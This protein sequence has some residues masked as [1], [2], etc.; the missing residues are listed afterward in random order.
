MSRYPSADSRRVFRA[1][2]V[3]L[4]GVMTATAGCVVSAD[5]ESTETM[6]ADT[7]TQE[8]SP[9]GTA[10]EEEGD[11]DR[12][13]KAGSPTG[14]ANRIA[15]E[16]RADGWIG[17]SPVEI[18]NL[19]NPTHPMEAGQTYEIVW[20]NVDGEEHEL[21]IE[22]GDGSELHASDST[23]SQ[24]ELVRLTVDASTEMDRYYCEY[25]PDTMHGQVEVSG[26]S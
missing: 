26:G 11:S 10:T 7:T 4:A 21:I 3:A 17:R 24:G 16:V 25:H 22:S 1:T 9:D 19:K 18:E 13:D 14:S 15:L 12:E 2:G 5:G 8:S 6:S 20:E 23:A